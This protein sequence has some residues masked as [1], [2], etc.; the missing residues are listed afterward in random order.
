MLN[1][2]N[3]SS[4]AGLLLIAAFTWSAASGFGSIVGRVM[5]DSSHLGIAGAVVRVDALTAVRTSSDGTFL[6]SRISP[7]PQAL[8][9]EARGYDAR[10]QTIPVVVRANTVVA[11]PEPIALH[12]SAGR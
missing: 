4:P 9:V 5:N 2:L 12:P 7:G 6:L 8:S 1:G 10:P 3:S 11:V